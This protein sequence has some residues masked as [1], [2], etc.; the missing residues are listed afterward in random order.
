MAPDSLLVLPPVP[1]SP[2][3]WWVAAGFLLLGIGCCVT[4]VVLWRTAP[5]PPG[6]DESLERLRS[7]ALAEIEA[8]QRMADPREGTQRIVATVKRF[9]GTASD[10]NADYSSSRQ[11]TSLAVRDPRLAPLA[12]FVAATQ[13]DCFDPGHTPDPSA[14]AARGREVILQWR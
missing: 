8:A 10:G 2:W 5:A 11:L 9:I 3:L 7:G 12:E 1:H 6:R 4:A 13:P 14:V